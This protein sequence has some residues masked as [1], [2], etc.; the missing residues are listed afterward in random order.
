MSRRRFYRLNLLPGLLFFSW[1]A[2]LNAQSCL[3]LAPPSFGGDGTAS[4][5]L[6]IYSPQ[7]KGPSAVQWSLQYSSSSV[8]SLTVTDGPA[9]TAV[10]KTAMCAGDGAAYNCMAAGLNATRIA[11][12]VIA[13]LTAVLVPGSLAVPI[14]LSATQGASPEGYLITV[15]PKVLPDRSVVLPAQCRPLVAMRGSP[16]Q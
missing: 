1:A 12:G 10:S 6:S 14:T 9:L 5:A 16:V 8:L 3:V 15:L 13:K 2:V 4:L 11:N 7:G